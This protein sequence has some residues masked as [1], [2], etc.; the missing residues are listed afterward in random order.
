MPGFCKPVDDGL[1]LSIRAT[2]K[3]AKDALAGTWQ[4][5]DGA[6]WLQARVRAVPEDG[7]ANAAIIV[8]LAKALGVSRSAITQRSG[9]TSRLK[10][11]HI[12]CNAYEMAER[13]KALGGERL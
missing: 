13:L 9:T 10:R 11:F 3:A 8:L 12:V 2:P 1:I 7:A 4:D 6:E 5:A